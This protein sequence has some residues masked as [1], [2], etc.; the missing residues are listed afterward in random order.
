MEIKRSGSQPSEQGAGRAFYRHGSID[1]LDNVQLDG[2]R[3]PAM[4]ER[5]LGKSGLEVSAIG[6]GCM[7]MSFGYGPPA[8]K[9]EMI[10]RRRCSIPARRGRPAR[11]SWRRPPSAADPRR[12]RWAAAGRTSPTR[13][14]LVSLGILVC[15]RSWLLLVAL[16]RLLERIRNQCS[17]AR[18]AHPRRMKM[19]KE[20]GPWVR[21]MQTGASHLEI[22]EAIDGCRTR[23]TGFA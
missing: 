21:G 1:P 10:S 16:R 19:M 8:D 3:S 9:Q 13:E 7:G 2:E 6:L 5:K 11:A 14:Q 22:D 18:A 17:W 23:L 20:R 4:Q 15:W 12:K